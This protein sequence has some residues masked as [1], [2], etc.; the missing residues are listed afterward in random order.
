MGGNDLNQRKDTYNKMAEKHAPTDKCVG[1]WPATRAPAHRCNKCPPE[2]SKW[3]FWLAPLRSALRDSAKSVGTS[4]N[5]VFV[6]LIWKEFRYFFGLPLILDHPDSYFH[7]KLVRFLPPNP[8]I[9]CVLA[10]LDSIL[11]IKY[12]STMS[13]AARLVVFSNSAWV[14]IKAVRCILSARRR[15][16]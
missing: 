10:G 3:M 14:W 4:T 13:M 9:M 2:R 11:H 7:F 15:K 8:I 16:E 1:K 12:N 5:G 6:T